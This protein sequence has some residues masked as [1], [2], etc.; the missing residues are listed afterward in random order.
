MDVFSF[1]IVM[2]E[3]LTGEEPYANMHYG[4]IIG[5]SFPACIIISSYQSRRLREVHIIT[6]MSGVGLFRRGW[7]MASNHWIAKHLYIHC[8]VN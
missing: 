2:W 4:A 8:I 3:L 7:H 5:K 6:I 1:G